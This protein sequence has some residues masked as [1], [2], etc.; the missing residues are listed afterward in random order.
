MVCLE[1]EQDQASCC[2]GGGGMVVMVVVVVVVV[3][4]VCD[5]DGRNSHGDVMMV[6][7]DG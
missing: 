5:G 1:S 7:G 2:D 4:M 6:F 3:M